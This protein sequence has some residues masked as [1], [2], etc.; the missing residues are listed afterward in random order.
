MLRLATQDDSTAAFIR[1]QLVD[2]KRVLH[3]QQMNEAQP[4]CTRQVLSCHVIRIN[5]THIP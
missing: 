1:S 2:C 3:M 4:Q 5:Q